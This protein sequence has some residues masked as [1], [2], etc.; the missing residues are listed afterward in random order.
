MPSVKSIAV[1]AGVAAVLVATWAWRTSASTPGSTP[2]QVS[3]SAD[4]PGI[5]TSSV[6]APPP[7]ALPSSAPAAAGLPNA[8][9]SAA[10]PSA[11][12]ASIPPPDCRSDDQGRLV[13][14]QRTREDIDLLVSTLS[15]DQALAKLNEACMAQ[16]ASA[17]QAMRGLYQQYVQYVK[18]IEQQWP[19]DEQ[20][21]I[22]LDQLEHTLHKGLKELRVQ[23]FGAERAC[24]LFCEEERLTTQ[25]L[26]MAVDYARRHPQ[27]STEQAIQAAQAAV[28]KD[29][30]AKGLLSEQTPSKP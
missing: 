19:V 15:G 6:P 10:E 28:M 5:I 8:A 4:R 16:P 12:V 20:T 24:A 17:Q 7:A 21:N 30:M 27:A 2:E 13:L 18:A 14:D 26:T 3:E 1:I 11:L 9:P 29:A 23:Y 25:M 22:P